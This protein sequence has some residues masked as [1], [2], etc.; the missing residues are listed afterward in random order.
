M[1]AAVHVVP[2]AGVL[3]AAGEVATRRGGM[4]GSGLV[5]AALTAVDR[6][7]APADLVLVAVPAGRGQELADRIVP[8]AA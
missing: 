7:D 8:P 5:H 4:G 1:R 2:C 6:L 3:R